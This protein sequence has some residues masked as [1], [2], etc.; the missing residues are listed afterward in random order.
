M[1]RLQLAGHRPIGLVGGATGLVGD[2]SGRTS[3]RTLHEPRRDR[4]LGRAHPVAGRA[5]P[6]TSRATTRRDH[7][8][9]PRVDRPDERHR[10]AAR[11]RQALQRQPH[12]R[13]GVGQRAARGRG[14]QLHRVQLPGHAGARLP[15]AVPS[16]RRARSSSAA[17]TSGATSPPASTSS[18]ASRG[19]PPMRWPRR[20]SPGPTARSSARAPGRRCGSTR[21]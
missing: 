7:R 14:H 12:A 17:A 8:Q 16:P 21:P 11:H 3:E 4:G 19:R 20:S 15:R 5:L 13:Q 2:P 10:L 6:A 9:Q 18:A 1:R